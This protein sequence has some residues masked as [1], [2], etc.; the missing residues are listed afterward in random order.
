MPELKKTAEGRWLQ[1]QEHLLIS[2]WLQYASNGTTKG[3]QFT[4]GFKQMARQQRKCL[5]LVSGEPKHSF[6]PSPPPTHLNQE[7][8]LEEWKQ[9][10]LLIQL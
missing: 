5:G 4:T 8:P 7:L 1:A 2:S 6:E 10:T 9:Q 3:N